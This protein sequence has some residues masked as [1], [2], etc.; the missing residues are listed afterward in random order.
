MPFLAPALTS[1]VTWVSTTLAAGGLQAF[2]LRTAGTLLLTAAA[3]KLM[4]RPES[5]TLARSVSVRAPVAPR[6]IVYGHRR[7]GG[8]IVFLHSR[9]DRD[10]YL[11]L[12]IA[13][14]GHQ[15]HSIGSV[16]FNGEEALDASGTAVGRYAGKVSV[17]KALGAASQVAFPG[18]RAAVPDKWTTAHRLAGIAAIHLQLIW[19]AD[20]FPSGLPNITVELEGKNDIRD[21]R[22]GT[23]GYSNNAAL[24]LADYLSLDPFGLGAPYGGTDGIDEPDL[25]EAANICDEDVARAGGGFEPRY[26]CNGI[27]SLDQPPKTNIEALLTAM[28]GSCVVEAG[29][30]RIHAGAWRAPDLTLGPDDIRPGGITL[31]S[32]ISMAEN[33]NAVRGQFVSPENDWQP[34]DFPAVTSD[35]YLAEDQGERRWHDIALPFTTSASCAQRLAKIELERTRC[36]MSVALSGKLP[37]WA[38]SVGGSVALD[39]PR[40]GFDAKPFEVTRSNLELI[41]EGESVA[42]V[43]DLTLR[44]ISPLVYDWE[45]SE[46]QIYAAAPRTSLPS[47]FDVPAPGTPEITESLYV[48]RDGG[49]LK[50][51]AEIIWTASSSAFVARYHIEAQLD[52]GDWQELGQTSDTRFEHRDIEAGLWSYRVKAVST[53]G[54]SSDWRVRSI[55][56]LGLSAPPQAL[57]NVTLQTAGGLVL[58]KWTKSADPDVRLGGA[59]V[60][61]HSTAATPSWANSVSMD[62]VAGAEAL[63]VVPAKPGTYLLRAEDSGGRQGPVSSVTTKAAQ[64]VRFAPVDSLIA[65]PA[66]T[67]S[68]AD[69]SV[70]GSSLQIDETLDAGG[71][72]ITTATE[73]LYTFDLGLDFG[74]LRRIRLR[75]DIDL[76]VLALQDLIDDRLSQIDSWA[77][78]DGAEGAEVDVIFETRETDDDPNGMPLWSDWGRVDSHEIEAR[79]IEARAWLR[80]SDTGFSPLVSKLRLYADEVSP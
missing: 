11:H 32:R 56:I 74:A 40:W 26:S 66:F 58:L 49:A 64:A 20:V 12:V 63:A 1:V 59:I 6:E 47:G 17:E 13:L 57:E 19:D 75:S 25:I 3:Q 24:C 16:F 4:P 72:R 51:K 2:L 33:C 76:S 80:T 15:V 78:F 69:L 43:P 70:T 27:V 5:G 55:E 22:L 65:D 50:I 41:R 30:W 10:Q 53:L 29:L 61:R 7:K 18:L 38:A 68:K 48:T 31:K 39:Y 62:R 73:G 54:V 14:A 46:E 35:V 45:A 52:G 28:A 60:I 34:D 42:L 36:Q 9:G 77:D 8:I 71:A 23:P 21:P 67:D 37:A 44:E 79:A